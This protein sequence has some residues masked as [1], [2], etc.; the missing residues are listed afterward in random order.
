[1]SKTA[2]MTFN[3]RCGTARKTLAILEEEGFEVTQR[4]YLDEP[5]SRAEIEH[6]LE[7]GDMTARDVL[8]AKEPLA[9]DLGLTQDTASDD[10]IIDAMVEH[11]ILLN[12]PI[13]E[14]DKGALL[15]RPQDEVRR[16]I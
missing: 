3:P 1:M 10:E 9:Q 6:L 16:I 13:V 4:R 11:P 7:K 12:R 8:R 2:W 15:A 5:L 14:T